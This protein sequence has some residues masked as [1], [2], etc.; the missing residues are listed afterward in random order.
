MPLPPADPSQFSPD[1]ATPHPGEGANSSG[2]LLSLARR[3]R[4]RHYFLADLLLLAV[5]PTLALLLRVDPGTTAEL[6]PFLPG[7]A[8]YTTIA[9]SL[10]LFIFYYFG[11]YR[12]YWRSATVEDLL[13]T[14]L[15]GAAATLAICSTWFL[16][17]RL[18][19]WMLPLPR[20]VPFID[21][22]L[23]LAMVGGIRFSARL[24]WHWVRTRPREDGRP[25]LIVGAGEAGQIIARELQRNPEVGLVPIGFVDDDLHKQGVRILNLPVLGNRE[26][27]PGIVHEKGIDQVIIAMPRAS[28]RTIREIFELCEAAGVAAKTVPA[29]YEI[30]GGAVSVNSLRN[31]EIEDLLRREPIQTDIEGV[32][33]LIRG[34]RVL[35]T[36]GGGSIGRELCRQVLQCHPKEL[37]LVG[38][39]ENSIFDVHNELKRLTGARG[40]GENG[41]RGMSGNGASGS[42]PVIHAVIADVRMPERIRTVLEEYRPEI[43]FHAAAH[44]HVPLMELNPS[45][46]IENN[47]LGTRNL[48]EA[49]LA[50][51]VERLVMISTDKAVNPT[52]IMGASKRAAEMVVLR[53]ARRS[54][55]PYVA[56]RFG[57]VLGSRGSVIHTFRR[58]I[59][60]G[61]PVTVSHPDMTRYF[62]TIPEAVQ[63]VLQ[64][65]VY[66]RG[67]EIFMLDMGDPVK[68]VDLARDLI[69][70]SGL[71]VDRDVDIVFSGVRPGEKLYEELFIPGEKYQQTIHPKILIAANASSLVEEDLDRCLSLLAQAATAGDRTAIVRCLKRLIPEY[72]PSEYSGSVTRQPTH[73]A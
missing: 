55:K 15:A 16:G 7:L 18:G 54:G 4:N 25:V 68:I 46:A 17:R 51:G 38:H 36:G 43:I 62:M 63:L 44:K 9:L 6:A 45:E 48:V 56:V 57:N 69:E 53:A 58:Q 11:L 65:S 59:A 37:V 1:G 26:R 31:I 70:L 2:R 35:V 60:E 47:I 49:A 12:R 50:A 28:G 20:S 72:Q 10:R 34:R 14:V 30:L 73:A 8:V 21:A 41:E 39:G 40:P 61:G 22:V 67:G 33:Q 42:A 13:Q 19:I 52:S 66:G 5:T 3:L 23:A 27:L 64:S 24:A 71:E 29:M 32:R